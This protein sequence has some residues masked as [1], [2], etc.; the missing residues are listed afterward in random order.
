ML[1]SIRISDHPGKSRLKYKFNLRSDIEQVYIE[2]DQYIQ[3][4]YPIK[5]ADRMIGEIIREHDNR[6]RCMGKATYLHRMKQI[7]SL[8]KNKR[9]FWEKATEIKI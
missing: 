8:N 7:Y 3:Y 1:G 2:M 9:G 6:I 4:F 5:E